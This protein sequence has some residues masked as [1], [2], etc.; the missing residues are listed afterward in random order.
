M[1]TG[2]S[3]TPW[4]RIVLVVAAAGL[5]ATTVGV[6]AT[7]DDSGQDPASAGTSSTTTTSEPDVSVD[8]L[9]GPARELVEL[10]ADGRASTYHAR[11]TGSAATGEG[12]PLTL[13][14]WAKQ[15]RFRQDTVVDVGGQAFHRANFVLPGEGA[16]CTRLGDTPW[17]C[18]AVPAAELEGAE[19]LGGNTL[20]QLRRAAVGV[21]DGVVA[22]RPARC[23]SI[24]YDART[25]ELCVS[26]EGVPLRI[27]SQSSELVIDELE[28][29]VDDGVFS[30][31]GEVS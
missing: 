29:D 8:D 23:F 25:T 28:G 12:G 10:L 16:S 20:D 2:P 3:A 13:E 11:Y 19:L 27:R 5:L 6:V 7:R 22:D 21:T 15:G 26:A 9:D 4:R 14:T 24:T 30:V 1:N 17:S 18:D 31:P